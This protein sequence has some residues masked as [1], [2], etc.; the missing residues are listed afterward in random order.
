MASQW[1]GLLE[2]IHLKWHS[3]DFPWIVKNT[4]KTQASLETFTTFIPRT[5]TP[6]CFGIHDIS[7]EIPW[8]K[9]DPS[10]SIGRLEKQRIAQNLLR[11][12]LKQT[13][14]LNLGYKYEANQNEQITIWAKSALNAWLGDWTQGQGNTPDESAEMR[15]RIPEQA[16]RCHIYIHKLMSSKVWCHPWHWIHDVWCF[17]FFLWGVSFFTCIVLFQFY[18]GPYS[19]GST[20][21]CQQ[22]FFPLSCRES[23]RPLN[24]CRVRQRWL[25]WAADKFLC[26]KSTRC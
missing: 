23:L 4:Q 6:H 25:R 24:K 16:E 9:M 14:G 3:H 22:C 2:W 5:G 8:R 13:R 21:S 19:V 1:P 18:F 20:W 26:P 12:H 11:V 17:S 15:S 10:D 7:R